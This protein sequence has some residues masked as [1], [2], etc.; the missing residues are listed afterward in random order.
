MDVKAWLYI[1]VLT[2]LLL[3]GAATDAINQPKSYAQTSGTS[4]SAIKQ[5]KF[6]CG[7]SNNVSATIAQTQRG[8]VT[9]IR[10]MSGFFSNSGFTPEK[11]CQAVSDRFQTYYNN[12]TLKYLT[13]GQINNQPV[14]CTAKKQGGSCTDVLMTLEPKDDPNQVL[15]QLLSIRSGATSAPLSRGVGNS[16]KPLYVNLDAYLRTAPVEP[17]TASQPQSLEPTNSITS[18][19]PNAIF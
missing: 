1:R 9:I 16:Q 12:G 19:L 13:T 15:R 5:V 7:K 18:D 4:N 3:V 6:I 10:W 11:R 14:I 8:N 2:V 17:G